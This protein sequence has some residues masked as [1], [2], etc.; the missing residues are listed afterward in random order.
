MVWVLETLIVLKCMQ[1][2]DFLSVETVQI[3]SF[4]ANQ[5]PWFRKV[6]KLISES[7]IYKLRK[8]KY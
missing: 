5:K 1:R 2:K 8:L 6:F 3:F 7:S 4:S